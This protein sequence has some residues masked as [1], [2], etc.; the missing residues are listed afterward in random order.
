M[1]NKVRLDV[2]VL[3][4]LASGTV[5]IFQIVLKISFNFKIVLKETKTKILSR[6]IMFCSAGSK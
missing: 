3:G 6:K 5:C 4:I 1:K 2:L